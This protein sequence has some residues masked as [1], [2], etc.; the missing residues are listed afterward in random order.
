MKSKMKLAPM[1]PAPPVTSSMPLLYFARSFEQWFKRDHDLLGSDRFHTARLGTM[2]QRAIATL[3]PI[4]LPFEKVLLVSARKIRDR[5][6][7]KQAGLPESSFAKQQS[8]SWAVQACG[9]R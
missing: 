5:H 9:A 3:H 4:D 7:A 8:R 2:H 1:N 6:L